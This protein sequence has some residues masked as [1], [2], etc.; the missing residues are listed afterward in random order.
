MEI[1]ES[2][3]LPTLNLTGESFDG[4]SYTVPINWSWGQ[5]PF[6]WVSSGTGFHA[7]SWN[8]N[9]A[10]IIGRYENFVDFNPQLSFMAKV[11]LATNS[12]VATTLL[13]KT[14]LGLFPT[15]TEDSGNIYYS[16]ARFLNPAL[17][18]GISMARIYDNYYINL[19]TYIHGHFYNTE[20][21]LNY[22]HSLGV[23]DPVLGFGPNPNARFWDVKINKINNSILLHEIHNPYYGSQLGFLPLFSQTSDLYSNYYA[24]ANVG[25]IGVSKHNSATGG[26]EASWTILVPSGLNASSIKVPFIKYYQNYLYVIM[27]DAVGIQILTIDRANGSLLESKVISHNEINQSTP[28]PDALSPISGGILR[29]LIFDRSLPTAW[30]GLAYGTIVL[31]YTSGE[32]VDYGRI[33]FYATK[34]DNNEAWVDR[35]VATNS[36]ASIYP[37]AQGSRDLNKIVASGFGWSV[38]SI[39]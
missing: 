22:V 38:G 30:M 35:V 21:S 39:G 9:Y 13:P 34:V 24:Y 33:G 19:P 5:N 27:T 17:S 14:Y 11:N 37:I 16:S 4:Q 1:V 31:D 7:V 18:A 6:G 2:I 10:W 3:D 32:I 29:S 8:D 36:P 23:T 15:L 25:Q 26:F 20:A 12:I 28:D